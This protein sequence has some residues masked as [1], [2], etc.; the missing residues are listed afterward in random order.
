MNEQTVIM[1]QAMLWS[2]AEDNAVNC[3]L[4]AHRCLIADG[5]QGVC[6]VRE[7][8]GGTLYTHTYGRLIA[9]HVD[10]IEKK[11]LLHF[12]PGS[13][14]Y[15]VAAPG[16]NLRCRWCQNADISQMPRDHGL[17]LGEDVTP[18]EIVLAGQANRCSSIAYTYTEPTIFFEYAYET[19]LLAKTAGLANV[20]VTNGFMTREMLE[21]GEGTID[22]ANVDLKAF[23][24]ETYRQYVGAR[25]Q[26]VLDNL[27]WMKQHSIWVEVTTLIIPGVN[28]DAQEL[29]DTARFIATDLGTDTPWH[30]SR[31]FP[32]Y[33]MSDTPP[34]DVA[35]LDLARR[36]GM[37]EGL[38]YIYVGNRP[39]ESNTLCHQCGNLLI[40]R[41]AFYDV[42]EN[43]VE[44]DGTCPVC[45]TRLAGVA[46]GKRS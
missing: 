43:R 44:P 15:S 6:Q 18:E 36:I 23:R 30:L 39:G 31:F 2:A 10:P 22:A 29:R 5:R 13:K 3:S 9:H 46:V 7:N 38:R 8:D 16:C 4:C 21:Q 27:A 33:R 25:L 20:W 11:P 45:H 26:P 12:Y 1:K 41:S 19:A 34:T 37:D 40:R 17:V 35:T 28:D 42:L 14:A 32:A 24:D